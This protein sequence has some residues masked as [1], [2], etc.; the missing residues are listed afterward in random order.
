[1]ALGG[2]SSGAVHS[3]YSFTASVEPSFVS[4]PINYTW[5][6]TDQQ[7]MT[8]VGGISDTVSYVWLSAGSKYITVTTTNELGSATAYHVITVTEEKIDVTPPEML[9]VT[10]PIT[11]DYG[12]GYT[13]NVTT[14]PIS[15]T[16]PITYVWDVTDQSSYTYP[17]PDFNWHFYLVY[18][19]PKV[20]SVTASNKAGTAIASTQIAI[21]TPQMLPIPPTAVQLTGSISGLTD[22]A[23]TFEAAV[24]PISTTVPI[25][26]V[27]QATESRR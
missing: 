10:G 20:I 26:Y 11:G 14:V 23:H 21:N 19:M 12:H 3:S 7:P 25:T 24:S 8:H 27:W 15:T 18:S 16:L 17:W 22:A 13:F 4:I 5:Q 6:A 9:S 2:A 1:M